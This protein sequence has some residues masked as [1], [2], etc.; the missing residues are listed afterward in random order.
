MNE[1]SQEKWPK[2]SVIHVT[3]YVS[4]HCSVIVSCDQRSVK[5]KKL[6]RF[7][8]FWAEEKGYMEIIEKG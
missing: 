5:R 8:P 4:D 1:S 3:I 7:E 6:F 2:T